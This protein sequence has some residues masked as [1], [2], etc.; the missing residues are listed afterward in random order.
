MLIRCTERLVES[1]E[2]ENLI[3][4]ILSINDKVIDNMLENITQQL[5]EPLIRGKKVQK[6]HVFLKVKIKKRFIELISR[7]T[8]YIKKNKIS[9]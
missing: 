4:S 3:E 7:E 1:W 9:I 5:H 8:E 2:K 6:A